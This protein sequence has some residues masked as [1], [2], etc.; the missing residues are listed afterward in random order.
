MT[1]INLYYER[2]P[3][4]FFAN[5]RER[6]YKNDDDDVTINEPPDPS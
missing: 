4:N 2:R 5:H 6:L 1:L 3:A